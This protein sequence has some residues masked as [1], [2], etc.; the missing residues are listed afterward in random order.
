MSYICHTMSVISIRL[1]AEEKAMLARKAK[2]AGI[3]SSAMA[4]QLLNAAPLTT[5]GELL[6]EMERLMKSNKRSQ[7][8]VSRQP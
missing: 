3:S 7:L 4:R 8:R 5:A 1:S 2:E 6:A